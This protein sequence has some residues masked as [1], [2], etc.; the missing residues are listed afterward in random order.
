MVAGLHAH[1]PAF[2]PFYGFIAVVAL[3]VL[4]SYREPLKRK[5]YLLYGFGGFFVMGL[6][7]R[8]LLTATT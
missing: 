6:A 7:V 4:F 2:H 5:V 3:G 1:P 8:A